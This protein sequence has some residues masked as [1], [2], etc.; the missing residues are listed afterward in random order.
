MGFIKA[1]N[2]KDSAVGIAVTDRKA[3]VINRAGATVALKIEARCGVAILQELD[4]IM[5]AIAREPR[6]ADH[7][8]NRPS[9]RP[10][11]S[12]EERKS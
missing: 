8:A 7:L 4:G 6:I 12:L 10:P 2:A 1:F 11:R 3:G 9:H 5:A